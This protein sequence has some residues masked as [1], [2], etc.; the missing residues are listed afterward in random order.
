MFFA[1]YHRYFSP[2]RRWVMVSSYTLQLTLM[3]A[4]ALMVT[5]GP[6]EGKDS[7]VTVWILVPIAL[8][9]FQSG[10]QAFTSRVLSYGGL[11]SVVLTSIYCDLFSDA[12]MFAA[13]GENVERNRR[14]AAPVLLLVGAMVGG[15][16]A[17]S[18]VGLAGALWSAVVLKTCVTLAWCFWAAEKENA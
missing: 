1:R 15:V 10:G 3:I 11:T 8:I 2:R 13:V 5:L 4:A 9:A 14:V 17:H 6:E 18:S 12:K 16:W 7:P